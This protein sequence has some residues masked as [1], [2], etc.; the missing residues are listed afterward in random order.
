MSR[1]ARANAPPSL[2][3]SFCMS[4]M[5]TAVRLGS[6]VNG[7]GLDSIDSVLLGESIVVSFPL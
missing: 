7:M 1:P 2:A 3:K 6:I 5:I 4:T